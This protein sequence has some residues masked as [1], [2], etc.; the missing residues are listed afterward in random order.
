M[1]K[2]IVL[3]AGMV[4]KAIA[5]DL[6]SDY[7]VKAIDIDM[8]KLESF[9]KH[10][11]LSVDSIDIGNSL[12][13]KKIIRDF[14]LVVGAV[15]GFMGYKTLQTI[16]KAGK[17]V[18]DIS[19]FDEDPFEL[20]KLAKEN[21]VTAIIDCGVAPGMMN[22]IL[23]Y[24]NNRMEVEDFACYVGGLPFKRTMPF[25]YKAPFSPADVIEIYTRP[26]R[27]IEN[28]KL[29][30]KPAMS[31]NELIEFD[32]VGTLEAFNT[33]GLRTLLKMKNIKNMKEKTLRYPGHIDLMKVFSESG[34]FSQ[35]PVS[36]GSVKVKPIELTS[37]LLFPLWQLEEGEDEF[38]A[39]KII[40]KGKEKKKDVTY[41]YNLFDRFD[42]STN[43]T[44]MARTTGYTCTAAARLILEN[45]FRVK[46]IIPPE[47]IGKDKKCFSFILDEL[48]KRNVK[49]LLEK[50]ELKD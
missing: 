36:A 34:F 40:I 49:Y 46:G 24:H 27:L 39:M 19:F 9:K 50:R 32:E 20:N 17:N 5:E 38:T 1:K 16:I 29:I 26:A 43:T 2:V 11:N 8:Q 45:K 48:R 28:G 21:G 33:D 6:L 37:K 44:S 4:G 47:Y 25:Q 18:V 31:D 3:G 15:P 12:L 13:L 7:F 30:T 23:G 22:I 41:I 10:K 35:D 42:K 14:D